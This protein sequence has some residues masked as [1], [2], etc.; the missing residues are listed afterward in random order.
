MSGETECGF[1]AAMVTLGHWVTLSD[2]KIV[3]A[4]TEIHSMGDY[5]QI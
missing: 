5:R 1:F 4:Q 2:R 3:Q